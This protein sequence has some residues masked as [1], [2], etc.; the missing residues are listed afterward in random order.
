[1]AL[2]A[3][4][5]LVLPVFCTGLF[6]VPL[7]KQQIPVKV[8]GQ[9]VSHKSAY[10]GTVYVGLPPQKFAVVFDSGSG[11]ICLP[12]AGCQAESCM[13]HR[14]YRAAASATILKLNH[15]G[16]NVTDDSD[17]R[18][19]VSV[20]YSTGEI[21]GDF[22][23]EI[24][25]LG[26]SMSDS[27]A[28]DVLS[29]TSAGRKGPAAGAL[30]EHC[31]DAR[32]I[33]ADEMTSEPFSSFDFDGV[34]GLGL[35]DLALHPDFNAVSLFSQSPIF[36]VFL[37]QSDGDGSELAVGGFDSRR[38]QDGVLHWVEL[39][40]SCSGYWCVRIHHVYVNGTSLDVCEGPDPCFAIVDT[41]TSMLGVPR[42]ALA[43][44]L[45][46]TTWRLAPDSAQDCRLAHGP[47]LTFNLGSFNLSL[48]SESY[49]RPLPMRSK[50]PSNGS[51]VMPICRASL[52][53]VEMPLLGKKVFIFGEP[54]LTRYYTVFDAG[55]RQ[56]GFG[57]PASQVEVLFL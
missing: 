29:W 2:K 39:A 37:G 28:R 23:K 6:V 40:S 34:M 20:S 24:I 54:V 32:V 35:S 17:E 14:R 51:A 55:Q 8:R 46:A 41:G 33:F 19:R 27:A 13:K 31:I 1:M 4:I 10:S 15:D 21:L 5:S 38:V 9:I 25:C 44:F 47:D 11:H 3:W 36:A 22:A 18:D 43:D 49:F 52:L 7:S 30:P 45:A 12:S 56:I 53:P 48:E 42:A 57:V 16:S 26:A 50:A